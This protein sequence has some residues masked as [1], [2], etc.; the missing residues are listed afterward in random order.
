MQLRQ[1]IAQG[2]GLFAFAHAQ[3]GIVRGFHLIVRH[4][5][6]AHVALT[7]FDSAYRRTFFVQ[8]IGRDWHRNNRVNFLGVLLQRFFFNQT[9]NGE[10]QG[11]V[12]A[13]GAGAATAR[14]DVMAGFAERRAQ[15][16]TRHFEQAKARNMADLDARAILTYGF[17]QAVF[18]RALVA[19][20]G[21]IDKVDNDK[22]AEVAQTQLAGNLIG[23]FKVGV[24]GGFFDIAAAGCACGVDIDRGQRLG[25]I[26]NDRAAGRQTNFTLE[27]GFDLRFDLVVAEQRDFT[28]VE[29]NF[30]AEVRATQ[31]GDVLASQLKHFRVID[32]NFTDILTQVVAERA[33]D[34][35]AFLVNQERRRAAFC[36]FLDSFPVLQAEAKV[37]LQRFGRFADARGAYN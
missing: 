32:K 11:F 8:Q 13:H 35:V 16:L 28:G 24:E 25:A 29:L 19:Y 17:A 14:A 36:G 31:R 4:D 37:P 7:G 20:R 34:D 10:R 26:D 15:A 33:H 6:N 21:H 27:S 1:Q 2:R 5:D 3:H 9:Q 18:Y 12:I 22:T 30:A 23:C